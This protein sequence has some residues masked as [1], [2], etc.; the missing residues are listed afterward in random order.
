M[1]DIFV[2]YGGNS[3][4]NEDN[5]KTD[6]IKKKVSWRPIIFSREPKKEKPIDVDKMTGQTGNN[7]NQGSQGTP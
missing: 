6:N 5:K 7:T 2:I 1:L 3:M 4:G